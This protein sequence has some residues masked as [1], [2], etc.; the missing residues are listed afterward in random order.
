MAIV[1][2]YNK[3]R[4]ITYVYE[5]KSYWDKNLKQPRSIRKLIGKRDPETGEIIPTGKRGRKPSAT[6]MTDTSVE[7]DDD[8]DYRMLY[9]KAQA[10]IEANE[11]T[12]LDLRQRLAS[13]TQECR[14]L[15]KAA[16]KAYEI[17]GN[18]LPE[19]EDDVP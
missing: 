8:T 11:K 7:P 5:S 3:S 14:E 4:G 9:K 15:R 12:I 13:V 10:R 16:T 19:Q 1:N 17:I 18:I 6:T 2:V